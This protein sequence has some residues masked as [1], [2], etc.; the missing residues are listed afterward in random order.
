[1]QD[2]VFVR[3]LLCDPVLVKPRM[4]GSNYIEV[5]ERLLRDSHEGVCSRH[6]FIM[7]GSI[8]VRKVL[9]SRVEAVSL[10]GDVRYDVQ[11]FANVCNPAIGSII[12]GRVINLNRFGVLVHSGVQAPDGTSMPVV[13]TIVTR[14]AIAGVESEV[15]LDTIEIGQMVRVQIAGKK[16]ELNDDK[17]S[18]IGRF[19]ARDGASQP[20]DADRSTVGT[21]LGRFAASTALAIDGDEGG[22]DTDEEDDEEDADDEEVDGADNA[23]VGDE[24]D[25]ED[26]E[27]D[28][29]AV[30]KQSKGADADADADEDA[31]KKRKN[32]K[33]KRTIKAKNK[34]GAESDG[35]DDADDAADDE[36]VDEDDDD[37]DDDEDD[38][39]DEEDDA[40]GDSQDDLEDAAYD[41]DDVEDV[42]DAK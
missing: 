33:S 25:D 16:F 23:S 1:M 37:E 19:V 39:D 26:D 9:S 18:V 8:A 29:D 27:D 22:S 36:D 6:G 12:E 10:N 20:S 35:D 40:A 3:S 34:D 28:D 21:S 7:P 2:I 4:L 15:D 24:E 41:D 13:E 5:V 30:A 14:Q 17:I 11:Y 38:D 42:E 32:K 31:D